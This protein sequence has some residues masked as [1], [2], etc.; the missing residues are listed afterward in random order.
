M[1]II[2]SGKRLTSQDQTTYT[3]AEGVVITEMPLSEF[4]NKHPAECRDLM[5]KTGIRS[6]ESIKLKVCGVKV[7]KIYVVG[8]RRY[9]Y[10]LADADVNTIMRDDIW[11]KKKISKDVK[12]YILTVALCDPIIIDWP[13]PIAQTMNDVALVGNTLQQDTRLADYMDYSV[14]IKDR[15]AY[16]G[17]ISMEKEKA[18]KDLIAIFLYSIGKFPDIDRTR[19]VV[20][21]KDTDFLYALSV[22]GFTIEE[23]RGGCYD[24]VKSIICLLL[25]LQLYI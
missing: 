5:R 7:L 2:P 25:F 1:K 18:I 17:L 22:L 14:E 11:G 3:S 10:Y 6:F 24:L 23:E 12:H 13:R 20:P 21:A 9:Y 15:C 4:K 16:F 8:N 19:I